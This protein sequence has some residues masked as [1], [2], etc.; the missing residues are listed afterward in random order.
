[1]DKSCCINQGNS[2]P[3]N[4]LSYLRS[5]LQQVDFALAETIL[6]LDTYPHCKEALSY[7]HKLLEAREKIMHEYQVHAPVTAL[8]NTSHDSWDWIDSPWPWQHD[9]N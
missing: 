5:R 6:Y 1:M 9:A 3:H 2:S 7:Y 8:G 4:H